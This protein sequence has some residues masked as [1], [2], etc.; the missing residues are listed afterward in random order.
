MAEIKQDKLLQ[1]SKYILITIIVLP[2]TGMIL[3]YFIRADYDFKVRN[4]YLSEN[5][6]KTNINFKYNFIVPKYCDNRLIVVPQDQIINIT[7]VSVFTDE[8]YPHLLSGDIGYFGFT[9]HLRAQLEKNG[10]HVLVSDVDA[11]ELRN[12]FTSEFKLGSA[13]SSVVVIQGGILPDTV[14][15]QN[16]GWVMVRKWMEAGGTLFWAGEIPGY[17]YGKK[18]EAVSGGAVIL[19][20]DAV[21]TLLDPDIYFSAAQK[22]IDFADTATKD[23]FYSKIF[24]FKYFYTVR[25]PLVNQIE[26]N[27][28][29]ILGRIMPSSESGDDKSSISLLPIGSGRIVIFG[30][31]I[32]NNSFTKEGEIASDIAKIIDYGILNMK[33][34]KNNVYNDD[35]IVS[36]NKITSAKES[37]PIPKSSKQVMIILKS[38][39]I[40]NEISQIRTYS[41][42]N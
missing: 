17:K 12:I 32:F 37:I 31:G 41:V 16:N 34:V 13:S 26:D 30:S 8:N 10:D 14:Y 27:N 22:N 4:F 3:S 35:S 9:D 19:N 42:G 11:D 39:C 7:R 28:G 36:T 21:G 24:D 2:I 29:V 33:T 1:Y 6:D 20:N 38:N 15:D 5:S 25:A 18:Y 23:S 40:A